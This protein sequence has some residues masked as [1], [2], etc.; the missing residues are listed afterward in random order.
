MLVRSFCR[1]FYYSFQARFAPLYAIV[2]QEA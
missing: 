1:H 2:I